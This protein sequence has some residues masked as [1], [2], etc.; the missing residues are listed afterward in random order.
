MGE[1]GLFAPEQVPPQPE[2]HWEL[3]ALYVAA[4]SLANI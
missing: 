2:A 4:T 1:K 3:V